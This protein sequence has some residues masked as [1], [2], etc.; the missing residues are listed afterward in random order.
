MFFALK[1]TVLVAVPSTRK[2]L[3]GKHGISPPCCPLLMMSAEI[4]Q[5]EG[6]ITVYLMNKI[7]SLFLYRILYVR[8]LACLLFFLV[9]SR[10]L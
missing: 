9:D 4:K 10:I 1:I 6:L 2:G 3:G 7:S 8:H 5:I